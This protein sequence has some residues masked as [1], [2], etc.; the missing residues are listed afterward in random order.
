MS[1]KVYLVGAGPGDPE[2]LTRRAH[3]LLSEADVVLHDELVSEEVLA[4]VQASA[5]LENVGKRCGP[6]RISQEEIGFRM[7]RYAREGMVVVRLKGGDPLV[8]GRAAEEMEVLSRSGIEFEI[9]P[10]ITSALSAAA[11]ARIPLTNRWGAS[12]LIFVSN[13]RCSEKDQADFGKLDFNDATIAVYMPGNDYRSLAARML[14]TGLSP[15]TPCAIVSC[16]TARKETIHR[17]NLAG[18]ANAEP[19]AAPA[20]IIIGRVAGAETSVDAGVAVGVQSRTGPE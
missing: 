2:L 5:R 11:A 10:G 18:L 20:T 15:D 16:S 7:V 4:C 1:G 3:R 12:K 6:K 19:L 14:A 8:F 9:V 13:H 17:S